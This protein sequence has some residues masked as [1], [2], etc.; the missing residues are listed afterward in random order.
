MKVKFKQRA[1]VGP[2]GKVVSPGDIDEIPDEHFHEDLHE[3]VE[4]PTFQ[5]PEDDPKPKGRK[6][7]DDG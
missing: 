5:P 1:T 2:I 7:K 4:D 6:S 3:K